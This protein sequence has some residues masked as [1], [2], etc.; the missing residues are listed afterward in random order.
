[1]SYEF[2]VSFI[3]VSS[4]IHKAYVTTYTFLSHKP[5]FDYRILNLIYISFKCYDC[6][7][8]SLV[9]VIHLN[10]ISIMHTINYVNAIDNLT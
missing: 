6:Q 2:R 7:V 8:V 9:K 5:S 4:D 10:Y 3:L 1:M